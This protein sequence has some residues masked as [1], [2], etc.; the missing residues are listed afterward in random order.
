MQPLTAGELQ[1]GRQREP[2][3][4]G[5]LAAEAKGGKRGRR[6]AAAGA[7]TAD[8]RTGPPRTCAGGSADGGF[9]SRRSASVPGRGLEGR[10]VG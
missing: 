7:K 6:P 1:L 8:V 2:T 10:R 9:R 5:R 4:D 3:Q